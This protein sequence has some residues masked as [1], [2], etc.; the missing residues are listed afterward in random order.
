MKASC[1][2]ISDGLKCLKTYGKCL[3]SVAR[4]SLNSFSASRSRHS[5]RLC[6]SIQDAKTVEFIKSNECIGSN[7]KLNLMIDSE[8]ELI[9]TIK[10]LA[11]NAT[12]KWEERFHHACCA[13]SR[14]KIK[15]LG[16]IE[17][18]C[19]KF[20][21]TTEEMLDSMVGELLESACPES[22]R[23]K[24]ICTRIGRIDFVR[25]WRAI[26]LTGAALDLIVVLADNP[27]D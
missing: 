19:S 22:T 4:R 20:K 26:S 16:D 12:L 10:M 11:T 5:K 7:K 6:A 25:E 9:T 27:R 2:R 15:V 21:V 13:A 18:E 14:Y 1:D 24:E 8:K 3:S 23:L 17:P